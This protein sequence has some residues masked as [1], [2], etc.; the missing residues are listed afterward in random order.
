MA[1]R[2][3]WNEVR[4]IFL[5]HK[6]AL[7]YLRGKNPRKHITREYKGIEI[8][9]TTDYFTPAVKST[10]S[11]FTLHGKSSFG[12]L[13]FCLSEPVCDVAKQRELITEY[14]EYLMWLVG[15]QIPFRCFWYRAD[16]NI[17]ITSTSISSVESNQ[18]TTKQNSAST[19]ESDGLMY[20]ILKGCHRQRTSQ[21][22]SISLES[23]G[24]RNVPPKLMVCIF[25]W[26]PHPLL[27]LPIRYATRRQSVSG[28][29]SLPFRPAPDDG[30]LCRSLM[31]ISAHATMLQNACLPARAFPCQRGVRTYL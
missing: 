16:N 14:R 20:N 6:C 2:T 30:P 25:G 5:S 11:W 28:R 26:N 29:L 13:F 7:L 21:H 24:H 23:S 15:G 10:N 1:Y 17:N 31:V 27:L 9:G 19:I 12:S 18:K 4:K 22:Q 8:L 3:M